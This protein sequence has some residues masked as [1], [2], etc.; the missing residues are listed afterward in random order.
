MCSVPLWWFLSCALPAFSVPLLVRFSVRLSANHF[1]KGGLSDAA[2]AV[3]APRNF[4]RRVGVSQPPDPLL[5]G[6][7]GSLYSKQ[8]FFFHRVLRVGVSQLPGPLLALCWPVPDLQNQCSI[9]IL[10]FGVPLKKQCHLN[11]YKTKLNDTLPSSV[12]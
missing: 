10:D 9:D 4:F 5:A 3:M 11:I 1:W 6:G 2:L 12:A 8:R 7:P